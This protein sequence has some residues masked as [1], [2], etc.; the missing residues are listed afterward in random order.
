MTVGPIHYEG[1]TCQHC[2]LL[3]VQT[4]PEGKQYRCTYDKFT[5]EQVSRNPWISNINRTPQWCPY[6]KISIMNHVMDV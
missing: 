2:D 1:W 4:F 5:D 6:L 3:E